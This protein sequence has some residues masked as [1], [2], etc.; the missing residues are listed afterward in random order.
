M[1]WIAMGLAL[2]I[3]IAV[4]AWWYDGHRAE[5]ALT[6]CACAPHATA[7]QMSAPNKLCFMEL[8]AANE[9]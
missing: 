8:V 9:C 4:G 5:S 2:V 3:V 7:Q 6:T 1:K